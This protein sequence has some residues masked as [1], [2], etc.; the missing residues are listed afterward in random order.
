[1]TRQPLS[2]SAVRRAKAALAET[3]R[4]HPLLRGV[5]LG[6][7]GDETVLRVNWETLPAPAERVAEIGGF[8]VEHHQVGRI[9]AGA[10][11]KIDKA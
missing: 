9:V 6:R 3:F 5:G 4:G 10:P 7:R 2:V 11:P 8:A 1:M